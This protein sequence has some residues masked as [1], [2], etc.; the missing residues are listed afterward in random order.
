MDK[1]KELI[2]KIESLKNE[3]KYN[4]AIKLLENALIKYN[5]DYRLY[6][7]LADIYLYK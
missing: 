3:Q 7:E 5:S 2:I 1:I 6:E 4:E